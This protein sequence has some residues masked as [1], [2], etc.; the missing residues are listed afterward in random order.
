MVPREGLEL[1]ENRDCLEEPGLKDQREL[2][3]KL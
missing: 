3:E 2:K 1:R